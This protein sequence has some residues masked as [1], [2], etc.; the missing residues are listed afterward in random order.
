M[1]I[2]TFLKEC[3]A[4]FMTVPKSV[5]S[6]DISTRTSRTVWN[7]IITEPVNY[8]LYQPKITDTQIS[9]PHPKRL[10]V[11][12]NNNLIFGSEQKITTVCKLLLCCT[13]TDNRYCF[14]DNNT[15]RS[16][17]QLKSIVTKLNDPHVIRSS[18][19]V[20]NSNDELTNTNII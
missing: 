13:D 7:K 2:L 19:P 20:T 6:T 14:L 17:N 18:S 16:R 15:I 8:F 3:P 1:S 10:H 4:R 11:E 12:W 9:R 5:Q